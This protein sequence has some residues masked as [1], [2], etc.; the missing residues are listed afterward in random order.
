MLDGYHQGS[1]S[2]PSQLSP[3]VVSRPEKSWEDSPTPHKLDGSPSN[4]EPQIFPSTLSAWKTPSTGLIPGAEPYGQLITSKMH[5]NGVHSAYNKGPSCRPPPQSPHLDWWETGKRSKS[6]RTGA[7][8]SILGTVRHGP[9]NKTSKR[10]PGTWETQ[11]EKPVH[12][13]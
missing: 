13:K 2:S 7:Q 3:A 10:L 12:Q 1:T 11:L 4:P 9:Q 8:G 6:K 5:I